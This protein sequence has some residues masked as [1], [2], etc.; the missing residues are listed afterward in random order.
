MGHKRKTSIRCRKTKISRKRINSSW[1]L[2]SRGQTSK[3]TNLLK[4]HITTVKLMTAEQK[5][6]SRPPTPRADTQNNVAGTDLGKTLEKNEG[7]RSGRAPRSIVRTKGRRER[8]SEYKWT[9]SE[10]RH[11]TRDGEHQTGHGVPRR[12][13]RTETAQRVAEVAAH[14]PHLE[15]APQGRA[16]PQRPERRPRP[17]AGGGH[18]GPRPQPDPLRPRFR[19]PVC[20]G[21]ARPLRK[22]FWKWRNVYSSPFGYSALSRPFY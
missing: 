6:D 13:L 4:R 16:F 14:A 1:E 20:R 2:Q 22:H 11:R 7:P 15:I 9:R 5:P 21:T 18:A 17:G 3:N 19:G 12:N 8:S 10:R